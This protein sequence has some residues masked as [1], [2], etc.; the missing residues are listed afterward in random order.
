L[1]TGGGLPHEKLKHQQAKGAS[2]FVTLVVRAALHSS[3][4]ALVGVSA[5]EVVFLIHVKFALLVLFISNVVR[6]YFGG[7]LRIFVS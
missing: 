4:S 7:M 2:H 6:F 1:P 5:V 3:C